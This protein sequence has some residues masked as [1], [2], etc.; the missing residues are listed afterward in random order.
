MEQ[1]YLADLGSLSAHGGNAIIK[2]YIKHRRIGHVENQPARV[3]VAQ[4][5]GGEY[6]QK[7]NLPTAED[8]ERI[9]E[10]TEKQVH[11]MQAEIKGRMSR[12]K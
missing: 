11:D 3:R 4:P 10:H 12:G 9:W 5:A 6:G 7:R 8:A 2:L 1:S